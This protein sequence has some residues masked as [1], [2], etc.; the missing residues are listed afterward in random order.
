MLSDVLEDY[1]QMTW[2]SIFEEI[3]PSQ[4]IVYALDPRFLHKLRNLCIIALS[5]NILMNILIILCIILAISED[6]L[7]P[8]ITKTI[9]FIVLTTASIISSTILY[10]EYKIVKTIIGEY[11]EIPF[12]SKICLC[13]ICFIMGLFGR[14]GDA[15]DTC[16]L[17]SLWF[18]SIN[19]SLIIYPVF[20]F[21]NMIIIVIKCRMIIT[22]FLSNDLFIISKPSTFLSLFKTANMDNIEDYELESRNRI[23]EGEIEMSGVS[24]NCQHNVNNCIESVSNNRDDNEDNTRHVLYKC[25]R[26]CKKFFIDDDLNMYEYKENNDNLTDGIIHVES[27]SNSYQNV[28]IPYTIRPYK[29]LQFSDTFHIFHLHLIHNIFRDF[30]VIPNHIE[31]HEFNISSYF[32]WKL[33]TNDALLLLLKLIVLCIT[34]G[35]N[36]WFLTTSIIFTILYNIPMFIYLHINEAV[37]QDICQE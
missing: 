36:K 12:E 34:G 24:T 1:D 13:I 23:N 6:I 31:A 22:L 15:L 27:S 37:I 2:S 7:F 28:K 10:K 26:R 25:I 5:G 35:Y 33:F 16:F 3:R 29:I 21:S 30:F 19:Y 18:I 17:L 11:P 4:N 9:L 14:V 20:I 32:L 8:K